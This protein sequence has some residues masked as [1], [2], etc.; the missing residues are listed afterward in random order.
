M[1]LGT[2]LDGDEGDEAR[3]QVH[4]IQNVY[5]VLAFAGALAVTD[6]KWRKNIHRRIIKNWIVHIKKGE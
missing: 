2:V 4:C 3:A 1:F 5:W 6:P